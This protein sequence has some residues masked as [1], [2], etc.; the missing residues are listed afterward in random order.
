MIPAQ[1]LEYEGSLIGGVV[2][3]HDHFKIWVILLEQG[4]D[5]FF[6]IL[7]FV[8]G[9]NKDRNK[10]LGLRGRIAGEVFYSD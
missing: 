1:F 8:A 3:Q 4:R 5:T 9:G 6:N 10:G 7:L 2:I